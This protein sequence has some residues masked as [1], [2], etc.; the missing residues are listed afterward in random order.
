MHRGSGSLK[1]VTSVAVFAAALALASS[2]SA[3]LTTSEAEQVRGYVERADHA[4]RVRALVAR[5]DLTA[6]ES[7]AV[8]TSSLGGIV[9]DDR[10]AAYLAEMVRGAPSAATRPVLAVAIIRGLL[11][12]VDALYAAHPADLERATAALAEIGLAYDFAATQVSGPDTAMTD[13]SRADVGRALSD[14]VGRNAPLLRLDAS[15]GPAVARLRA[16]VALTMLDSLPDGPTRKI[17][18]ADKLGVAGARRAVLVDMGLLVLDRGGSDDRIA[19]VRSVLDR[20]P[21][22]REGAVALY[23]G[24]EHA[25]LRSRGRVITVADATGPLG[26]AA[27]PWGGEADPPQVAALTMSVARGLAEAAVARAT[28]KRPGLGVQ[29]GQDGGAPGVATVVAMLVVDPSRT[30]DV[31]CAR[32]ISG[33]R[34]TAAWLADAMGVLAV[35]APAADPH[36]G[37]T[38]PLG[39][40]Q[41]THVALDPTGAVNAF[42]LDG[43]VWRLEREGSGAVSAIKRDGAPV[44]LSMLATARVAATD[45]NSWNGA[46]L[47]FARLSGSPRVAISA[48]P[49]VR[50]VG[51]HVGDAI[52]AQAP[53]DD[54]TVE[55]DV[56][57]D[58]GPAGIVLHALAGSMTFSGVSLLIVPGAPAHAVLMVGDGGGMET[59]ASPAVEVPAAPVQHVKVVVKGRQLTASVGSAASP[60]SLSFSLPD[61]LLH[62]DVALRAYPGVTLEVAGWQVSTAAGRKR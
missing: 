13:A 30:V 35:S 6:D 56:H 38:L 2:A 51:T 7:A 11:S 3:A 33:R 43:H 60:V 40:G 41:A 50:L 18:A 59:A 46:G 14:H 32:L 29:I 16:Q 10:H 28:D 62:G 58:G 34:E 45:G 24:D 42:R 22:A 19:Q 26:E 5:P 23:I 4:D 48:G 15:V 17:D 27:S 44:T 1:R 47:V 37:L 20:M 49:R 8:M 61:N 21:Q 25:P 57:I 12:R 55:A 39:T 9:L 52:L 31:A 54:L 53:G 36:A